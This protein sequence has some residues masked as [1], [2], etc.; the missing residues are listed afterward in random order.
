[1]HQLEG[2]CWNKSRN[3]L[4]RII[5]D[6]I[7]QISIGSYYRFTLYPK[8]EDCIAYINLYI[9]LMIYKKYN[10]YF[11]HSSLLYLGHGIRA[12]DPKALK[13]RIMAKLT[14]LVVTGEKSSAA[15]LDDLTMKIQQALTQTQI[16]TNLSF[17]NFG[18]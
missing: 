9:L 6:C 16:S 4:R 18:I 7:Y 13:P 1:M 17:D 2:E 14:D 10:E 11:L 15:V 8:I 3:D 12:N 5:V